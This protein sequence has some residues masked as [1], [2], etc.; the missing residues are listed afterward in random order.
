MITTAYFRLIQ[1]ITSIK[2]FLFGI[3]YSDIFSMESNKSYWQLE[4]S[5]DGSKK[6]I[7]YH[8]PDNTNEYTK[9][10][11]TFEQLEDL[12]DLIGELKK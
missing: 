12:I 8:M 1:L 9:L 4:S 7:L 3:K 6:I 10:E 11:L 2:Y 5:I